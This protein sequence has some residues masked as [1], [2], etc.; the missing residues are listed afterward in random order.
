MLAVPDD[1]AFHPAYYKPERPSYQDTKRTTHYSSVHPAD[2]S[3]FNLSQLAPYTGQSLVGT[4]FTVSL[5][6][7]IRSYVWSL[8]SAV[9]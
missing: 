4:R 3:P 9:D 6:R 2:L 7:L 8:L 1:P 5:L